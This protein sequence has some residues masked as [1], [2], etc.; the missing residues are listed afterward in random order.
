MPVELGLMYLNVW[1]GLTYRGRR[2]MA[3]YETLRDREMRFQ[4][5]LAEIERLQPDIIGIGEANPLPRYIERLA[6]AAGYD[7]VWHMG[8]SGLRLGP[9]GFPANLREGD[10]I[11]ARKGLGLRL[12]GRKRLCGHGLVRNYGSFH[13]GDVT[14][15]VL[16]R[17]K[18]A[19]QDIYAGAT[20]WHL[21][22]RFADDA[23][24][25]AGLGR[26]GYGA[27]DH[28]RAL[29]RM[30]RDK[31]WKR[32]E[33]QGMHQWLQDNV[34]AGAPLIV[35]GDFNAT[36]DWPEMRGLIATGLQDAGPHG[37]ST[38]DP[39]RNENLKRYYPRDLNR[40]FADMSQHVKALFEST[41]LRIDYVLVNTRFAVL[42]SALC[43]QELYAGT[44]PS[45][46]FGV[47]ARVRIP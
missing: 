32:R 39:T 43:A 42:S 21:A 9:V 44:H 1:S 38:W 28:R 36:P 27:R 23:V 10:A 37:E 14:Q 30:Q 2:R 47:Y 45:D 4:G 29:R 22:P 35:M 33:A 5:L 7:S 8:V 17:L 40:R 41:P 20:H 3:A 15:I 25:L 19:D 11:L 16:A 6:Q 34:P 26:Y 12:A 13:A 46:H 31:A 18:V 24:V